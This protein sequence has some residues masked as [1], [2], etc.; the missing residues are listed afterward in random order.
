MVLS[1]SI[2]GAGEVAQWVKVFCRASVVTC[3]GS[4]NPCK[5]GRKEPS[6]QNCPLTSKHVPRYVYMGKHVCTHI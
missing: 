3:V 5:H 4:W 6:A 2:G 1:D